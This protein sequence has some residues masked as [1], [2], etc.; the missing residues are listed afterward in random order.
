MSTMFQG[1][2]C[3]NFSDILE[4]LES[5]HQ[6]KCA[7]IPNLLT[8]ENIL[9]EQWE[10]SK[11]ET[12]CKKRIKSLKNKIDRLQIENKR[13]VEESTNCMKIVELLFLGSKNKTTGKNNISKNLQIFYNQNVI[14]KCNIKN[15]KKRSNQHEDRQQELERQ[16][17]Q[18]IQ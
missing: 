5:L 1:S 18:Q 2:N 13:F 16:R 12:S 6:T 15:K 9:Y 14:I 8:I 4:H 3:K 10:T 17:Q 7:L 11:C